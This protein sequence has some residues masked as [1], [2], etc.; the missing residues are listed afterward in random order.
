ML[1][2]D[3]IFSTSLS[4]NIRINDMLCS[5]NNGMTRSFNKSAAVISVLVV[6]CLLLAETH[7]SSKV[8]DGTYY[9]FGKKLKDKIKIRYLDKNCF[10]LWYKR[11]ESERFKLIYSDKSAV[12]VSTNQLQWL[13]SFL[14]SQNLQ[15]HAESR[16]DI[17]A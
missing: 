15:G 4:I 9:V 3:T 8:T 17:F 7:F 2:L 11:L 5:S 12:N 1:N 10:E 16:Y 14:A 6:C 13:L